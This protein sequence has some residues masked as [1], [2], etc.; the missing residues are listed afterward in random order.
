MLKSFH[1]IEDS[2]LKLKEENAKLLAE[3]QDLED[4]RASPAYD[5]RFTASLA[6]R[7]HQSSVS[8]DR[9]PAIRGKKKTR[10]R[11]RER[12]LRNETLRPELRGEAE[13]GER[14]LRPGHDSTRERRIRTQRPL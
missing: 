10:N 3:R 7:R 6:S 4:L 2:H 1:G 5:V 9:S 13:R 11:S 8:R 12:E 14:R